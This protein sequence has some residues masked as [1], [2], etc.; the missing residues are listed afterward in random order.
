MYFPLI[1][2]QELKASSSTE[3]SRP[4]FCIYFL[5]LLR[6]LRYVR[7][8]S[9]DVRQKKIKAFILLTGTGPESNS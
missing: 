4:N 5:L 3:V 8:L 6:A 1:Y 9:A 7:T 2:S